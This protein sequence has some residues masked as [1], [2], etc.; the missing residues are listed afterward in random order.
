MAIK[1]G[2]WIDHQKALVVLISDQGEEI[3]RIKS[4]MPR[5]AR[6]AAGSSSKNKYTPNDFVAERI[7]TPIRASTATRSLARNRASGPC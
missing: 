3:K 4:S 7:A 2:V 5:R 6:L 1:A